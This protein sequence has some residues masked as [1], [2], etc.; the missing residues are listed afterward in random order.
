MSFRQRKHDESWTALARALGIAEEVRDPECQQQEHE[1]A[2]Q[3]P[4]TAA[5]A[6]P[7]PP[8]QPRLRFNEEQAFSREVQSGVSTRV[9]GRSNGSRSRGTAARRTD[10]VR[11]EWWRRILPSSVQHASRREIVAERLLIK[12]GLRMTGSWLSAAKNAS[13]R[14]EHFIYH[15]TFS[16]RRCP[17]RGRIRTWCRR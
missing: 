16:C 11:R 13:Y 8:S 10:H 9:S 2:S 3:S 12:A 15:I 1:A 7:N 17:S 6:N 14:C 4:R 5:I